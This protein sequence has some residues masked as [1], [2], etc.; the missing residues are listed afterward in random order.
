MEIHTNNNRG[1]AKK[2]NHNVTTK[3]P[4]RLKD[5]F[6][7]GFLVF[8]GLIG[9]ATVTNFILGGAIINF[10]AEI[11]PLFIASILTT[12]AFPWVVLGISIAAIIACSLSL[13]WDKN[14]SFG[15]VKSKAKYNLDKNEVKNLYRSDKNYAAKSKRKYKEIEQIKTQ[16]VEFNKKINRNMS[17]DE[18]NGEINKTT[19]T[20]RTDTKNKSKKK[21][22]FSG[23]IEYE[24]GQ[25]KE[26]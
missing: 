22:Q 16:I 15:N 6:A 19:N 7:L 8:F 17:H 20:S 1:Q 12:S 26:I 3:S 4:W 9:V 13:T 25:T 18:V 14:E 21:V 10:L 24:D 23:K 11:M 2:I 5:Y